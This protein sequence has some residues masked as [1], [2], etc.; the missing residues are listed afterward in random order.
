LTRYQTTLVFDLKDQFKM[1]IHFNRFRNIFVSVSILVISVLLLFAA[2]CRNTKD[3]QNKKAISSELENFT[4]E[5]VSPENIR[6]RSFQNL[7]STWGY[8]IFVNS[9]PYIHQKK[10]PRPGAVSGFKSKPDAE[11]VADF[12]AKRISIG[13][14]S[15]KI[16]KKVL[17]S[18]GILDRRK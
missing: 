17:D 18:L 1:R 15:P 11:A 13:D 5:E 10:I 3:K 2:G 7:D 6:Y 16:S 9:R 12:I 14:M 4:R 8:T